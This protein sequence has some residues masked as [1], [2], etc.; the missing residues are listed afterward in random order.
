[1]VYGVALVD[2]CLLVNCKICGTEGVV[3]NYTSEEWRK[4]YNTE[5]SFKDNNRVRINGKGLKE[6]GKDKP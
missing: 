3:R 6:I 5:Y 1:L 4:A 2:P